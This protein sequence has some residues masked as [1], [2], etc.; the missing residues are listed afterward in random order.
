MR[1]VAVPEPSRVAVAMT[2]APSSRST[3]PVGTG[4]AGTAVTTA[5][6]VTGSPATD[7]LLLDDRP[8]DAAATPTVCATATETEAWCSIDP[9]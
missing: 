6:R 9:P 8:T 1:K 2:V 4:P 5:V 3:V 7:G